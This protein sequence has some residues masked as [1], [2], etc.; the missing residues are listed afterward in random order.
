MDTKMD[1][2]EWSI[3]EYK[4]NIKKS[5]SEAY[6]MLNESGWMILW[7]SPTYFGFLVDAIQEAGFVYKFSKVPAIWAKSNGQC[8]HPDKRLASAAEFFFYAGKEGALINQ[9]GRANIFNF[10]PTKPSDKTHPTEKPIQLYRSIF[11][12]FL[13]P[14]GRIVVAYA[15]SGNAILGAYTMGCTAFGYDTAEAYKNEF[16]LK[17]Y[18]AVPPYYVS[19]LEEEI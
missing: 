3:E 4:E 18:S 15:G 14:G 19:D 9:Q 16:V 12:T 10:R 6:R 5:I 2:N 1:Y 13:R 17:A 11:L 8:N 7:F